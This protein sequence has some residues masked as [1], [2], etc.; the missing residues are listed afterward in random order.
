[1]R[2]QSL[3]QGNLFFVQNLHEKIIIAQLIIKWAVKGCNSRNI[4][5]AW[6]GG[7][8]STVLLHLIQTM[9]KDKVPFRISFGDTRLE[10]KELYDF[11]HQLSKQWSLRLKIDYVLDQ[12]MAEKI[13]KENRVENI[14]RVLYSAYEEFLPRLIQKRKIKI[15]LWGNRFQD[16]HNRIKNFSFKKYG[17]LFVYPLLYFKEE[18]IWSYIYKFNVPFVNLY[19]QGYRNIPLQPFIKQTSLKN[20]LKFLVVHSIIKLKIILLKI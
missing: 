2:Q 16:H 9:Y 8:E 5:I 17:T 7:K 14:W 3:S 18:D 11:L 12:E 20:R 4:F 15:L 6:S 10:T 19:K 1:M 13:K